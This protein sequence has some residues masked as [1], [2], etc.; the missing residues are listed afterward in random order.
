[1]KLNVIIIS[2]I[3]LNF[4]L[5]IE[6]A[7]AADKDQ[8][9]IDATPLCKGCKINMT[10]CKIDA[11]RELQQGFIVKK[12]ETK[13]EKQERKELIKQYKKEKKEAKNAFKQKFKEQRA[14][15][16]NQ[17]ASIKNSD[18][19]HGVSVHPIN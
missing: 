1:M 17:Q 5:Y 13:E 16:L 4:A 14:S 3:I 11:A 10:Q 9:E 2:F 6:S 19:L 12:N 15:Y 8:K 18:S 7:S